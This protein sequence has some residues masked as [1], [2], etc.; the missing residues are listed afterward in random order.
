MAVSEA[1]ARPARLSRSGRL[2]PRVTTL[3]ARV[4]PAV[5]AYA[6]PAV[7]AGA[8]VQTWFTDGTV[9]AGGDLA[10]PVV[11]GIDYV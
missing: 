1:P 6:V 5:F 2:G 11:A 8:A 9:L 3:I 4:P 7:V 10:P